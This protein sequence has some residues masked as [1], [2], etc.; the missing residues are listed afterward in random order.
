M[1]SIIAEKP[2]QPLDFIFEDSSFVYTFGR[3]RPD[4][5][6]NQEQYVGTGQSMTEF[7]PSSPVKTVTDQDEK[8]VK[9]NTVEPLGG[10][11][12]YTVEQSIPSN[13]P[14]NFYYDNF[15]FEDQIESCIEN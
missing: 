10:N 5:P 14:S 4:G 2:K 7:E 12:T 13:M 1:I 6:T 11:W 8:D 3:I 15:S 9:E